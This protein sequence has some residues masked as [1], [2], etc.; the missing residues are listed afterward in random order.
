MYCFW[1]E[2]GVWVVIISGTAGNLFD[3]VLGATLERKGYIKN[4]LVN[5]LNTV[6]AALVAYLLLLI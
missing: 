3:S 4:N 5:F 6:F 1:M 2:P